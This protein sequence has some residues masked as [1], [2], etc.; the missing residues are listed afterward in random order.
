MAS[1]TTP[2]TTTSTL[3]KGKHV[4]TALI[5]DYQDLMSHLRAAVHSVQQGLGEEAE[6]HL[7]QAKGI[8]NVTEYLEP[9]AK[10]YM[11][12]IFAEFHAAIRSRSSTSRA[13]DD[14]DDVMFENYMQS[15]QFI[16][17]ASHVA[18][19]DCYSLVSASRAVKGCYDE[20]IEVSE[21]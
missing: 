6:V 1:T 3:I 4:S 16:H 21:V 17:G 19:S 20:A 8:V 5:S 14:S 15:M 11:T 7:K 18:M 9:N 12:A 2:T 13:E 10:I